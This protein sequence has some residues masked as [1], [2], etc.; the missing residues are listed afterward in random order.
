M[1]R[2]QN[3]WSMLMREVLCGVSGS[4]TSSSGWLYEGTSDANVMVAIAEALGLAWL[5]MISGMMA[6]VETIAIY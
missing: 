5:A 3:W 2:P 4:T 6:P 1:R